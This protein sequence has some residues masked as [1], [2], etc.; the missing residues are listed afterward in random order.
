M[1]FY[2]TEKLVGAGTNPMKKPYTLI[3]TQG[4]MS[5][6][7]GALSRP[8]LEMYEALFVSVLGRKNYYSLLISLLKAAREIIGLVTSA[9]ASEQRENGISIYIF[10]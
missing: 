2:I 8:S 5:R 6:S 7:A 1:Y 4:V 10:E 9:N 3:R